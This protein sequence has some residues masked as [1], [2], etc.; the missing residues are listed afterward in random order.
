MTNNS[1]TLAADLKQHIRGDVATDPA[2]LEFYS[3]DASL[4][5][6][7]PKIVVFPKDAEDIKQLVRYVN[8][9]RANQ[10]DLSLTGRAG[11]TDMGGGAINDS[12]IV[13]FERHM[14]HVGPVVGQTITTEPGV[15]Y[16]DFETKTLASGQLMPTYPASRE[17]CMIGGMVANNAGGEKSLVYGKTDRFVKRLDIV[18]R[19]GQKHSFRPISKA[20]LAQK[21][22]E[23]GLEA[24]LYREVHKLVT[25]NADV[26][27]AAKPKVSKNSTAYNLWDV[28]DGETFDITKVIVGSQ[29]TL[30]LMTEVEF[31]LVPAMPAAG[32]VV[33]FLPSLDN[34]GNIIN[35]ILPL[36][37][38]SLE[39]FDEH[40]LKFAFRFFLGFRKTLGLKRFILLGLSFIPVLNKLLRL[41]PHLPK[42]VLMV[43]FEDESQEKVAAKI[44]QTEEKLEALGIE[45]QRAEDKR[46]EEKFWTLRRE[47]FNLLRKNIKHKH[48]A[49]FIDDIIVPPATL[50]EF[51]PRLTEILERNNLLYT[52]AGHMGDG[53][54]HI[55][56]LMDLTV[57]A[58]RAKIYPVLN[59]VTDLILQYGGS[60]SGEHNDGM[61]R[62]PML[63]KMYGPEV[64]SIMRRVKNVFDPDN[65][66]NPHKKLTADL[67]YSKAHMREH[68]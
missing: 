38:M 13:A 40:T 37:P 4:F 52:V 28:W 61:I 19:D 42:I 56:P 20:E 29:G 50:Q 62:G 68:F 35:A 36:Q 53:N 46:H 5:E 16:R 39:S 44:D 11:G 8:E 21:L 65:I 58:E 45:T 55:I 63:E 25:E 57:P 54:F 66:F 6:L 14:N 33:A 31:Q 34:L 67:E 18:L 1:E 24:D 47:S 32:M 43:H 64:L 2:S 60:L 7:R 9:H 27:K 49:P 15:Y 10:P 12:L 59:E 23:P 41:F 22:Q 3:H 17:L 26:L 30:G 51:L 48:T